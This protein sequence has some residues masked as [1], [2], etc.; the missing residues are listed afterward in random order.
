MTATKTLEPT[1]T[2][3]RICSLREDRDAAEQ[4]ANEARSAF[5]KAVYDYLQEGGSPTRLGRLLGVSRG[6]VYTYRDDWLKE[7]ED[8]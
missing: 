2:E 1:S 4:A 6:T 3:E 8:S 7:I 5:R